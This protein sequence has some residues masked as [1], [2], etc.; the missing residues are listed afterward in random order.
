[1]NR[2]IKS[3]FIKM[4]KSR[5]LV[6][7]SIIAFG[8]GIVMSLLY[9]NAWNVIGSDIESA[10]EALATMGMDE[11]MI[12]TAFAM[13]PK[14][15][16]WSYA[17]ILFRDG[18]IYL[19]AAICISVFA[20]SEYSMGTL[21]NTLSRG[22]SKSRIY[23]SKM[24]VSFVSVTVLTAAYIAG[25]LVVCALFIRGGSLISAGDM[26][27]CVVAYLCLY[28]AI[29]SVYFM[30]STIIKRTGVAIAMSLVIPGI[31]SSIF[32]TLAYADKSFVNIS[33]YWIFE[34]LNYVPDMCKDGEIYISILTALAY[35]VL[36]TAVGLMIFRKQ[37]VK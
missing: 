18:T 9:V 10:E 23:C 24:I 8:L 19:L 33:K 13:F 20:A 12:E 16:V 37:E 3:D 4:S 11:E 1:M 32:S 26:I 29:T 2:L 21:K 5:T 34:T 28:I 14:P 22:F 27:L 15:Y 6:I 30:L 31:V 35:F 7:C 25:G 17:D 36:S